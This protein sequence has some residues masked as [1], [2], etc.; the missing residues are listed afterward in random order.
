MTGFEIVYVAVHVGLLIDDILIDFIIAVPD[1]DFEIMK[2]P[3]FVLDGKFLTELFV[4]KGS[5]P[6][7]SAQDCGNIEELSAQL[8]SIFKEPFTEC[9]ILADF[10]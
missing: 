1:H 2:I 9:F 8:L 5:M 3:A 7:V 4:D 6:F 10:S